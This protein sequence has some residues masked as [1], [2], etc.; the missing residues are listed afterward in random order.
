MQAE[1]RPYCSP[2][3][4]VTGYSEA[5]W[6]QLEKRLSDTRDLLRDV[7]SHLRKVLDNLKMAGDQ[8]KSAGRAWRRPCA[9]QPQSARTAYGRRQHSPFSG[10]RQTSGA[11]SSARPSDQAFRDTPSRPR[12]TPQAAAP[13]SR[14]RPGFAA[15]T[16]EATPH[17]KTDTAAGPFSWSAREQAPGRQPHADSAA[18]TPWRPQ[19]EARRAETDDASAQARRLA[20]DRARLAREALLRQREA[21]AEK[22]RQEAARQAREQEAR[23]R[24][25]RAAEERAR[26]EAREREARARQEARERAQREF[27]AA[28]KA[29]R[30]QAR[31]EQARRESSRSV[32]T[33]G[34]GA[35]TITQ[36]Y[37]M[38]CVAY[39]C[40]LDDIKSAYRKQARRHHPDLGGDEEMMKSLNHA[41][42][43]AL[44]CCSP[45][46]G[47]SAASW[48]A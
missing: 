42:E 25:A 23:A 4:P 34:C 12:P 32:Y 17:A 35:M 43:M 38:L 10:A 20:E 16:A 22:A 41:Y 18:H 33:P 28:Q 24:L 30:E 7:L 48:A 5:D 13:A 15:R 3:R 46:R 36:A 8:Y 1:Q 44:S 45:R 9:Q 14:P 39:P 31:R 37:A 29:R 27:E 6:R 47:K 19:A 21:Q 26:R 40:S 2:K 11:S